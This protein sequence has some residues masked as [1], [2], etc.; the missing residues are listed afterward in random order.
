MNYNLGYSSKYKTH[1]T[2]DITAEREG[3]EAL[4]SG[5][6]TAFRKLQKTRRRGFEKGCR[7]KALNDLT[8]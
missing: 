5:W 3:E 2:S 1:L 8:N 7:L 4:I 6:I